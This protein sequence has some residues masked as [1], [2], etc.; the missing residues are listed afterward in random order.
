MSFDYLQLADSEAGAGPLAGLVPAHV[1]L[2][3]HQDVPVSSVHRDPG[4]R[5]GEPRG[6]AGGGHGEDQQHAGQHLSRQ[7]QG[8]V[9]Y[10]ESR[11]V[12]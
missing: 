4:G 6:E 12:C 5:G 7:R 11:V 9:N 1:W 2:E 8:R 10:L 3:V